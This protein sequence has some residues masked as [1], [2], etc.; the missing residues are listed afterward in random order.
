MQ[1]DKIAVVT[2]ASSGIGYEIS[3]RLLILGYKVIGISRSIKDKDINNTNFITIQADLSTKKG[4]E[5]ATTKLK[6]K[7]ISIL[8]NSAGFGRFE[9]HEELNFKTIEDMVY[10]ILQHLCL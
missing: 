8:I 5:L 1:T 2:G 6:D 7:N 3:K 4:V 9:P 10:L